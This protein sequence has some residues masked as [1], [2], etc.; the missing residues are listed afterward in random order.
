[1]RKQML[2]A[3][4]G[5]TLGCAKHETRQEAEASSPAAAKSRN[6]T[7]DVSLPPDSPMLSRI[8]VSTVRQH[9]GH[10]TKCRSWKN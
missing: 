5:M 1:M 3:P 10:W 6:D 9:A 7:D 2:M 8:K 4:I